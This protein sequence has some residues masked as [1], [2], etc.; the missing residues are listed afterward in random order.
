MLQYLASPGGDFWSF[1]HQQENLHYTFCIKGH[2]VPDI[3]EQIPILDL[4]GCLHLILRHKQKNTSYALWDGFQWQKKEFPLQHWDSL[5]TH[6]DESNNLYLLIKNQR[7]LNL[8]LGSK[9]RSWEVMELLPS[10]LSN[11]YN[12]QHYEPIFL[13][14]KEGQLWLYMVDKLKS[15]LT[16]WTLFPSTEQMR[17]ERELWVNEDLQIEGKWLSNNQLL[18]LLTEKELKSSLYFLHINLTNF[19]PTLRIIGKRPLLGKTFY[20]LLE[21]ANNLMLIITGPRLSPAQSKFYY[22]FSFDSGGNWTTVKSSSLFAPLALA[23]VTE[24]NHIP[25]KRIALDTIYGVPLHQPLILDYTE[26]AAILG[27]Q[28]LI[29]KE[30][31]YSK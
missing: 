15:A 28:S 7:K 5:I 6:V 8:V 22:C 24:I 17:R 21:E 29:K 13:T 19:E 23:P 20:H 2:Q 10:H 4:T 9:D 14:T 26:L 11:E 1:R 31:Y 27:K 30:F 18:L 12:E 3:T 16:A 25:G